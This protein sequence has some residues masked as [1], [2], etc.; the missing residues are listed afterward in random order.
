M[1]VLLGL[2]LLLSSFVDV[3]LTIACRADRGVTVF[4]DTISVPTTAVEVDEVSVTLLSFL[5]AMVVG[6]ID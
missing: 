3:I 6:A 4:V 5:L 1:V 2:L